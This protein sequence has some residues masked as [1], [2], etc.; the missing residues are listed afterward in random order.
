MDCKRGMWNY[1]FIYTGI[2]IYMPCI[3][4]VTFVYANLYIVYIKYR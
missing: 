4:V 2:H 1:V 3:L